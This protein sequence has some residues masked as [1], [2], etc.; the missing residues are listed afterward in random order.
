LQRE[1]HNVSF[2]FV[3]LFVLGLFNIFLVFSS[4]MGRAHGAHNNLLCASDARQLA[5]GAEPLHDPRT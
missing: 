5:G 1:E 4:V 3:H 2:I